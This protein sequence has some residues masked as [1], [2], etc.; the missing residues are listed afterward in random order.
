MIIATDKEYLIVL[1]LHQDY[2]NSFSNT[3]KAWSGTLETKRDNYT[4]DQVLALV[5]NVEH[6]AK[7]CKVTEAGE[8]VDMTDAILDFA[9]ERE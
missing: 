5:D 8:M 1:V 9:E 7:V 3:V 4:A 2:R 6:L